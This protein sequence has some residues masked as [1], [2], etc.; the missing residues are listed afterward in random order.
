M[1]GVLV[2]RFV[3]MPQVQCLVILDVAS[4]GYPGC[5]DFPE[6]SHI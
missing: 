5:K 2:E 4:Y 6:L 1:Y 3:Q